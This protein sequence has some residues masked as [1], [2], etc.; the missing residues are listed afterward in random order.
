MT[1]FHGWTFPIRIVGAPEALRGP[2]IV[3]SC[4]TRLPP[5]CTVTGPLIVAAEE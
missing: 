2:L 5:T 3:A 1:T 4:T